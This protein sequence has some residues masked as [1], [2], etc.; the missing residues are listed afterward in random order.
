MKLNTNYNRMYINKIEASLTLE[1]EAIT[2]KATKR[3]LRQ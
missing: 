2:Y 1:K 3:S